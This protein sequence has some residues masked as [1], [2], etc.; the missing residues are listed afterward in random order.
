MFKLGIFTKEQGVVSAENSIS[1]V[2]IDI[3]KNLN[4]RSVNAF[5][6]KMEKLG[7]TSL[8]FDFTSYEETVK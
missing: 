1:E 5:T 2:Q 3:A 4:H 7:N 6:E 8:G